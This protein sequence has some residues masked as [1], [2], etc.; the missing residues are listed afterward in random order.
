[1]G[2]FEKS[3]GLDEAE[4]AS[5]ISNFKVPDHALD[6][7]GFDLWVISPPM[8]T[9]WEA[10]VDLAVVLNGP[11]L[12]IGVPRMAWGALVQHLPDGLNLREGHL[13]S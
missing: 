9:S 10:I 3:C 2:Q 6:V 13:R 5:A 1:V 4:L 8:L 12:G 11:L 7:P